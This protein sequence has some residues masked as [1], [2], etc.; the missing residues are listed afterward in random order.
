MKKKNN[1]RDRDHIAKR[2]RK[3]MAML[4]ATNPTDYSK[5]ARL[6]NMGP[7]NVRYI[8]AKMKKQ[9]KS[10]NEAA[11]GGFVPGQIAER[12]VHTESANVVGVGKLEKKVDEV[13]LGDLRKES[14]KKVGQIV[15][16]IDVEYEEIV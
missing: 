4:G 6:F 15:I 2:N 1:F 16:K 7:A 14:R 5:V 3:I 9:A 11:A 13:V 12:L 10:L 8:E